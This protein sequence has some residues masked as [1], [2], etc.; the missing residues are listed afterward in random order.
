M[1]QLAIFI[2]AVIAAVGLAWVIARR[3]TRCRSLGNERLTPID[4]HAFLN[5]VDARED[6]YLRAHLPKA[7]YGAVRR[8]RIHAMLAYLAEVERNAAIIVAQAEQA[9]S[10]ASPGLQSNAQA[11]VAASAQFR[12]LCTTMRMR[13]WWQI[14]FPG[15]QCDIAGLADRYQKLSTSFQYVRILQRTAPGTAVSAM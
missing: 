2:F 8:M 1:L 13:L 9:I 5:L 4:L 7:K 3:R 11:V 12:V 6:E 10:S 14:V 15:A